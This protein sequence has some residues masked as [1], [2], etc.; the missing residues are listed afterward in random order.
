VPLANKTRT[1]ACRAE[2]IPRVATKALEL[3]NMI[4]VDGDPAFGLVSIHGESQ[5]GRVDEASIIHDARSFHNVDYVF[6]RRFA[7]GRSSQV[8]AYV[9]DNSR[10]RVDEDALARLH[11]QLWLHGAA[12][13][14]YVA[15]RTRIDILS[16]ARGPDFW[17]NDKTSY[18]PADRIELTAGGLFPITARIDA[19]LEGKL[20]RFSALRLSDGTFWDDP[21][22]KDLAKHDEGAHY[23]LIQAIVE[24]DQDLDGHNNA[25]LR[26]LLVLSVLIKYLED[27]R[28]FPDDWFSDFHP[29]AKNFLE[30]LASNEPDKVLTLLAALQKKFQGDLFSLPGNVSL[31]RDRLK[32]FATLVEAKTLRSQRYLWEQYS[33][34]HLPVEVISRI[35]QRFVS[36]GRGAFYTP[37]I[38]ATML[39]DHAIPYHELTG[40]ERVLDPSCGSGI[41]L[42][43]AFK[44][45]VN[46]WRFQ[47]GWQPP[48]VAVL[49]RI[50][51]NSIFGIELHPGAVDLAAFSLALAICDALK[52]NVIWNEL[53]FD[54]ILENNLLE[55]DFFSLFD[56]GEPFPLLHPKRWPSAEGWPSRFN[57]VIGNPPFESALT[58]AGK[59]LDRCLSTRRG[60]LPDK[61]AAYLFLEQAAKL[62]IEDG[63]L[64]L[65]QPSGFLYNRKAAEF[66][67]HVFSTIHCE[68]VLDLTS[69]RNLFDGADPKTIAVH[70]RGKKGKK[71]EW[72]QHVTF[73]RTFSA[74][75]R[76]GFELDHYD[77][78]RVPQDAAEDSLF[79][80]RANLLGGGRLV[81]MSER[82]ARMRNWRN[83]ILSKRWDYS[84]G[85]IVG[86]KNK[87]SA[88]FLHGKPLLPTESLTSEGIDELS[89]RVVRDTHF[90]HPV[91]EELFQGPLILIKE[92]ATLPSAFWPHGDLAFRDQIV[93]IR[94]SPSEIGD[95]LQVFETFKSRNRLYQFCTLING[96]K[97]LVSKATALLKQDIDALPYPEHEA[98]LDLS[99]WEEA[100]VDDALDY[101]ASFVRLG[102]NSELLTERATIG[103]THMY[104]QM[105]CRMLGSV[106]KNI[107]SSVPIYTNG[108]ICQPFYFGK[109]PKMD[110]SVNGHKEE[111]DQLIY[112]SEHDS[113][114]TVRIVRFYSDNSMLIVKPDR[115]RYWIRSTAI[116]DADETLMDLRRQ[117]Y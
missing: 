55:G 21:A 59:E 85:F 86:K 66:R 101:M 5:E 115:L 69:I 91:R 77:R 38:L 16:C 81:E 104:A 97:G 51:K 27:R 24:A 12:P 108:L 99:F 2:V 25:I 3:V 79:I 37:P 110:W 29:G 31:D 117:G 39:L 75:Q 34:E 90:K 10:D 56:E 67:K 68:E 50:L 72:I 44:R 95:L 52:P 105:F 33:F 15:W 65:L 73:R 103:Q 92:H 49:K 32:S 41:F 106:Y 63:R 88:A 7:D 71:P 111:L 107:K 1:V 76:I 13:L 18:R 53:Q 11:H 116:R 64:C 113:L 82:F 78:H 70:A 57:V 74:T 8:A 114:R 35:Y 4:D 9:I 23:R 93:G 6:F 14:M 61:Q 28:V 89:I 83:F 43:G 109:R 36:D 22:N 19:E 96:S 100:L 87:I 30:V 42:V 60:T 17:V 40:D 26:R 58:E 20:R 112:K 46:A 84:E 102:Q 62:L 80:W 54:P 48:N 47:N 98:E 94:S 45:L